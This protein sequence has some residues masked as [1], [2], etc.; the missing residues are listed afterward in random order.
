MIK[1]FSVGLV[2]LRT[3]C[4]HSTMNPHHRFYTRALQLNNLINRCRW[5]LPKMRGKRITSQW[6]RLFLSDKRL[7]VG[8]SWFRVKPHWTLMWHGSLLARQMRNIA[9]TKRFCVLLHQHLICNENNMIKY[10]SRRADKS[11]RSHLHFFVF[12]FACCQWRSILYGATTKP[13]HKRK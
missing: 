13:T 7:D 9:C 5:T 2:D 1:V 8:V 4:S 11:E 3:A 12:F 10:L 6:V